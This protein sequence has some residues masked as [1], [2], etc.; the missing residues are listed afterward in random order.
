MQNWL[1]FMS[2]L[3]CDR[4]IS[5]KSFG[6]KFSPPLILQGIKIENAKKRVFY[7]LK[8]ESFNFEG[9]DSLIACTFFLTG[10]ASRLVWKQYKKLIGLILQ[11]RNSTNKITLALGNRHSVKTFDRENGLIWKKKGKVKVYASNF[12][13]WRLFLEGDS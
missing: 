1:F 3:K 7:E 11:A 4:K 12:S 8:N 10:Y 13:S 6:A 9:G 5:S 2:Q